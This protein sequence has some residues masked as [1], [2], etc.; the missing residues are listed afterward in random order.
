L[1]A[2]SAKSPKVVYV[3]LGL[4]PVAYGFL[5]LILGQDANWDLRNYHFYNPF[6]FLTG[7]MGWDIAISH[8]ATYYN[9]LMY[10]PF[11]HALAAFDPRAVGF[12]LGLLPGLNILLLYAVAREVVDLESPHKTA[13]FCMAIALVGM[14]GAVNLAEVGTSYLD[15]VVSLLPLAAILIVVRCREKL[16]AGGIEPWVSAAAA[17][18]LAGAAFGLKLPFAVYA[19]G[20]CAAFF[21]LVLPFRRKFL[22]AFVFGLGVLAGAA[23]T[24]GFWMLEMWE[25]FHNPIFPYFNEVF[26]SPWGSPGSYRDDRFIPKDIVKTVLFPFW[27]TADPMQVGEVQFRDLRFPLLYLALIAL[28]VAAARK[29]FARGVAAGSSMALFMITFMGVSFFLWMKLFAVYRYVIVCELLAPL[30]LF[31]ALGGLLKDRRRQVSAA[32]AGFILI[33]ITLQP[34]TWGRRPWASDYFGV[35]PPPLAKPRDTLVLVTGYDPV[36]YMIPFFP[37]EVRFLRIQGFLTGPS[38]TP[39][40]SDLTMQRIVAQHSGDFFILY[41]DYEEWSALNA[42]KAYGFEIER[43]ECLEWTPRVEPQQEHPFYF[44]PLKKSPGT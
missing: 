2:D 9:P 21:G 6:A 18:I 26:K 4:F 33:L 19:V 1:S 31:L 5:A 43:S 11:Y 32:L 37:P 40:E 27:F 30:T 3:L 14:L 25:R 16:N 24:G 7:R 17:G 12:V 29:R 10:L 13:W 41:R 15:S 35:E 22:L 20:L 28:F 23:L 8:V 36:A 34:G 44:C 38:A 42:L 39:N